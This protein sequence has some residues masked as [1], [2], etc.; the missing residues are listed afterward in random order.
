MTEILVTRRVGRWNAGDV[1]EVELDSYWSS[2]L[3][4]GNASI[5][6]Q[7]GADEP[8]ADEPA[9]DEPDPMGAVDDPSS[10]EITSHEHSISALEEGDEDE[11]GTSG[12]W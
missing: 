7:D 6:E 4:A 3:G 1:I 10:D 11:P 2:Q 12:W 9:A 5:V 8:A